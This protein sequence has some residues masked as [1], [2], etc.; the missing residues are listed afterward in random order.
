MLQ[1]PLQL[2]RLDCFAKFAFNYLANLSGKLS[3][4]L[5]ED[6]VLPQ[7]EASV[8]RSFTLLEKSNFRTSITVDE[9]KLCNRA[10][11]LMMT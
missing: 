4:L 10:Y 2:L 1:R 6:G 3:R 8:F 9:I 5:A 11:S 7:G